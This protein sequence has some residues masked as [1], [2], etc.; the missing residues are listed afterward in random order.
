MQKV[1]F[2]MNF[3]FMTNL[4]ETNKA[5]DHS[6]HDK[7]WDPHWS[8][9][10]LDISAPF[11]FKLVYLHKLKL[12]LQV[13][14]HTNTYMHPHPHSHTYTHTHASTNMLVPSSKV[15]SDISCKIICFVCLSCTSHIFSLKVT[16]RKF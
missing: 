10:H 15:P 4:E 2:S 11:L 6:I 3:V 12:T 13:H 16:A 9:G 1:V 14:A 5:G 8:S 7:R